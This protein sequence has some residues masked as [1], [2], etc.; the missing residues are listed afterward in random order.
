MSPNNEAPYQHNEY[1]YE[2]ESS[3]DF[4]EF[5]IFKNKYN[6]DDTLSEYVMNNW[7]NHEAELILDRIHNVNY[8]P[9][10]LEKFNWL[11]KLEITSTPIFEINNL[12]HNLEKLRIEESR[13]TKIKNIPY[14]VC[15]LYLRNNLIE[16]IDGSELPQNLIVLNVTNNKIKNLYN[17]HYLFAL[18][19]LIIKGNQLSEYPNLPDQLKILNIANNELSKLGELPQNLRKLNCS[20]NNLQEIQNLPQ[21]L[22]SIIAYSNNIKMINLI[23]ANNLETADFADNQIIFV[24]NI[25][26]N[27]VKLNLDN[28]DIKYINPSKI[29]QSI[30]ELS[31][32]GNRELRATI[33]TTLIEHLPNSHIYHDNI[34]DNGVNTHMQ[35][36]FN[37][38]QFPPSPY[39]F[40]YQHPQ[41]QSQ[42]MHPQTQTQSHIDP[43]IQEIMRRR[44]M[45]LMEND[46]GSSPK[47]PI[48]GISNPNYILHQKNIRI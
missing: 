34:L 46:F 26:P 22:Q 4:I 40:R 36:S 38:T 43:V 21:N 25:P 39:M 29:P 28:N 10:F 5:D 6:I 9:K 23:S 41:L 15:E 35:N 11:T 16:N 17:M 2:Y 18:E 32:R 8:V 48:Y 31:I 20:N 27:I 47:N 30:K 12:P 19:T 14:S 13:I 3:N 37:K 45:N 7:K 44:M 33:I 24:N 42:Q 1:E